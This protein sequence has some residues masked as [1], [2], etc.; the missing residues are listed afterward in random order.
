MVY[1]I[2]HNIKR[3]KLFNCTMLKIE[4]HPFSIKAYNPFGFIRIL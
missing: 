3:T 1:G 4:L 2:I